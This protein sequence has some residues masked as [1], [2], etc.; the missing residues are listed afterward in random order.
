MNPGFYGWL[1]SM[2]FCPDYKI[3][4]TVPYETR[5]QVER[6]W[7][8]MLRKTCD[9][10]NISDGAAPLTRPSKRRGGLKPGAVAA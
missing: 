1:Q 10:F 5:Y 8:I 3:L 4:A 7:T 6:E 2:L 9:L